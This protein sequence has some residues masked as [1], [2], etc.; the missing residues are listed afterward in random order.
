[1]E[2]IINSLEYRA[3]KFNRDNGMTHDDLMSID[4]FAVGRCD[5]FLAEFNNEP[6]AA[7]ELFAGTMDALNDLTIRKD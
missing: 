7:P 5:E 6:E 1:M 3:Y 2:T 4:G